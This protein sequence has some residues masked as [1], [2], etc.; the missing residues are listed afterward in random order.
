MKKQFY[1]GKKTMVEH[2][3]HACDESLALLV[4]CVC[5]CVRV[6]SQTL[7][8]QRH[9]YLYNRHVLYAVCSYENFL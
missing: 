9:Q 2:T 7:K 8:Q 4:P 6:R 3:I 1:K 5:R